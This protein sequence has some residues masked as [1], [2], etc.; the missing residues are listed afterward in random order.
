[1]HP[2]ATTGF[3]LIELMVVV[4]I[5]AL[6]STFGIPAYQDYIVRTR[7]AEVIAWT[8]PLKKQLVDNLSNGLP[9]WSG[10]DQVA[11]KAKLPKALKAI[12][13]ANTDG[14]IWLTFK[15]A[16]IDGKTMLLFPKDSGQMLTGTLTESSIPKGRISWTC[17]VAVPDHASAA[18]TVGTLHPKYAPQWCS[19]TP[20]E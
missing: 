18:W 19:E 20:L 9:M 13:L 6:L 12:N 2:S 17:R 4:A 7:V 5:V 8:E 11:L 1:M 16:P 15:G 10:V 14:I 3:T